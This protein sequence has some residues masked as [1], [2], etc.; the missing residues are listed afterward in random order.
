MLNDLLQVVQ[1]SGPKRFL[2]SIG[3][4]LVGLSIFLPWL[5]L[6]QAL[7]FDVKTADFNQLTQYS[8]YNAIARQIASVA[9]IV[10]SFFCLSP[11]LFTGGIVFATM[12]FWA[13]AFFGDNEKEPKQSKSD[14]PVEKTLS[15]P[16]NPEHKS[17][18]LPPEATSLQVE[19]PKPVEIKR[20]IRENARD[21]FIQ[22]TKAILL[23][24]DSVKSGYIIDTDDDWFD[25]LLHSQSGNPDILIASV[26]IYKNGWWGIAQFYK[27]F[28]QE[29]ADYNSNHP[30]QAIGII[31]YPKLSFFSKIL[32]WIL[33]K[34]HHLFS[35]LNV[36]LVLLSETRLDENKILNTLQR[37]LVF[38]K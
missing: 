3:V 19:K 10:S 33:N 32:V 7:A 30:A 20:N 12:S 8:Q 37:E 27:T 13:W 18:S 31:L 23:N 4:I 1:Y 2:T 25:V 6:N 5:A 17:I 16:P 22:T 11:I 34:I 29:W 28:V 24:A 14:K 36:Q 15:L 26:H 21:F 9:L 35:K 38:P